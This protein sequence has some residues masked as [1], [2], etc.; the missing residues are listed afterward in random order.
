MDIREFISKFKNHPV[1]FIDTGMSLRYL[2]NSFSWDAL[3]K[4]ISFD[5]TN[6][7]EF[8]YDI[9]SKYHDEYG[10]KYDLIASDLQ[11]RFDEDVMNDRNGKFK[12]INDEFYELMDKG[13]NIS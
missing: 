8:F 11:K 6:S 2:E 7:D 3:L 12:Y 10:Y 1:L 5:L 13:K 9:K 4:R